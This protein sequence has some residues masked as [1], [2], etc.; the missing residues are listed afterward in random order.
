[1]LLIVAVLLALLLL[2]LIGDLIP[3][4]I[5]FGAGAL[6]VLAFP[7]SLHHPSAALLVPLGAAVAYKML[8]RDRRGTA[9]GRLP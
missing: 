8:R 2:A 5:F 7:V 1:M 9:G 3:G 6:E 4:V